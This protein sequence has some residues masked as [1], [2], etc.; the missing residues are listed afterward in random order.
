MFPLVNECVISE[1][2]LLFNSF[3]VSASYSERDII[4]MIPTGAVIAN[5]SL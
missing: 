3:T 5:G 1:L 4:L 2:C